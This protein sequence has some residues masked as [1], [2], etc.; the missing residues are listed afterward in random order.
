MFEKKELESPFYTLYEIE[1]GDTLYK[2]SKYFNVNTKLLA[3]LNGIEEEDYIYPKQVL[4]IPKDDVSYYITKNGDT[5]DMV[6][7]TFGV[8]V[9]DLIYQNK[10]I[11]L[12]DGQMIYFKRD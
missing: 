5:L 7:S 4:L 9:R 12:L 11:Y 1:K 6:A 3:Q 10:S 8:D 2:I